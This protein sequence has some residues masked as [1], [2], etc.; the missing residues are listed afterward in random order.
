MSPKEKKGKIGSEGRSRV[1][2]VGG[3][4]GKRKDG[5]L[6]KKEEDARKTTRR[7]KEEEG[8]ERADKRGT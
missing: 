1:G 8:R 3:R 2:R 4:N 7:Q 5:E 6:R